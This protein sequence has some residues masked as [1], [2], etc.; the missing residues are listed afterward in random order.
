[1]YAALKRLM[2]WCLCQNRCPHVGHVLRQT[3]NL[4]IVRF[5]IKRAAFQIILL[6][7]DLK[8]SDKTVNDLVCVSLSPSP[9]LS[10]INF[11]FPSQGRCTRENCKYLHPPAHLKTQL[12]INGRN[13]LIQ[14][15]TAAAMLA[16]QMQ[17]MIPGTTMQPVV[18]AG[19]AAVGINWQ[20]SVTHYKNSN[21]LYTAKNQHFAISHTCVI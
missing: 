4:L 13:N 12:E 16:Q 8:F 14:Q 15:K 18:S 9:H 19:F 6:I 2:F 3:C 20:P 7:R 10:S 17:F 1:M 21:E 5:I 11:V